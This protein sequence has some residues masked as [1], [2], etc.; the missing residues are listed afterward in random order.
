[1]APTSLTWPARKPAGLLPKEYDA[2]KSAPGSTAKPHPQLDDTNLAGGHAG[3][4]ITRR[5]NLAL[6]VLAVTVAIAAANVGQILLTHV[7]YQSWSQIGTAEMRAVHDNWS[8]AVDVIIM[9]L[10]IASVV[11]TLAVVLV[12][13]PRVPWWSIGLGVVLQAAT[14]ATSFTMWARWQH[15]IGQSGYVRL[16]DGSLSEAYERIMDTHWLRIALMTAFGVL[17]LAMLIGAMSGR[18][19]RAEI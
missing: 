6:A 15:E 8:S 18:T 4:M 11:C 19:R 12:R 10:A 2:R 13:H 3:L 5:E 7:N 9:P 1:M 16:P 14:F 17:V